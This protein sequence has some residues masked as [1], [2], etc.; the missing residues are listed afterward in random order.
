MK[1]GS[2]PKTPHAFYLLL[3]IKYFFVIINEL[4]C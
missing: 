3:F 2:P 4:D 1:K